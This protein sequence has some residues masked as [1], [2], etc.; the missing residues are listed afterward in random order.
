M[1]ERIRPASAGSG[2]V[3]CA[4]ASPVALIPLS[5]TATDF[6]SEFTP[7]VFASAISVPCVKPN[8]LSSGGMFSS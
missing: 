6:L 4:G 1:Q 5:P 8:N 7:G 2:I 3:D